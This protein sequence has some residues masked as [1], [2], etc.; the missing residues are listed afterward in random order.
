MVILLEVSSHTIPLT[1]RLMTQLFGCRPSRSVVC[2]E[3]WGSDCLQSPHDIFMLPILLIVP[4]RRLFLLN[5][6]A[7]VCVAIGYMW[8]ASLVGG[9]RRT[10]PEGGR[11]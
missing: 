5:A 10:S 6:T 1:M 7:L 11:M 3:W 9:P 2:R 4:S 8:G